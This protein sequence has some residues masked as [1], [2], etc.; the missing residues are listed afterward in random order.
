MLRPQIYSVETSQSISVDAL[1]VQLCTVC[2]S[3]KTITVKINIIDILCTL[4]EYWRLDL[5]LWSSRVPGMDE[6]PVKLWSQNSQPGRFMS[7]IKE[8]E[9]GDPETELS[10]PD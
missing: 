8:A 4:T 6:A 5:L 2:I 7:E 3:F 10:L 1:S 9:R